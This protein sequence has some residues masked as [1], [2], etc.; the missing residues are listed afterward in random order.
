MSTPAEQPPLSMD[1]LIRFAVSEWG[2]PAIGAPD[3]QNDRPRDEH[4]QFAAADPTPASEPGPSVMDALI[5][6]REP[7]SAEPAAAA[8]TQEDVDQAVQDRLATEQASYVALRAKAAKVDA[9][10]AGGAV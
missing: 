9:L 3:G 4:G 7:A 5:R 8:Y 2:I 10:E 1:E 6:G